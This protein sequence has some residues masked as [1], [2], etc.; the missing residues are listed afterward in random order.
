MQTLGARTWEGDCLGCACLYHFLVLRSQR[1][2]GVI[3]GFSIFFLENGNFD[4]FLM[5]N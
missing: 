5:K 1:S 3:W 4:N 2:F